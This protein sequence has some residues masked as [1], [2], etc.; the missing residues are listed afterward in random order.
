MNIGSNVIMLVQYRLTHS[1]NRA[2]SFA[3]LFAPLWLAFVIADNG[4][5]CQLVL[6]CHCQQDSNWLLERRV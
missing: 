3:F 2:R 6:R 4:N 5:T 1:N